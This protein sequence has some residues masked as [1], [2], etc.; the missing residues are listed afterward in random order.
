[1]MLV[2]GGVLPAAASSRVSSAS[3]RRRSRLSKLILVSSA[4][5]SASDASRSTVTAANARLRSSMAC[6]VGLGGWWT[7][8]G[9]EISVWWWVG[10]AV[11]DGCGGGVGGRVLRVGSGRTTLLLSRRVNMLWSERGVRTG[12]K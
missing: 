4:A 7:F 11:V 9:E 8:G 5:F 2:G 6:M 10:I 12:P 1:M 3:S